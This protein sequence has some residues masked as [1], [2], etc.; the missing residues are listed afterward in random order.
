MN[1]SAWQS[2]HVTN[3]LSALMMAFHSL[4]MAKK[5]HRTRVR[6]KQKKVSTRAF[7]F[8]LVA[9][10]PRRNEPLFQLGRGPHCRTGDD[11]FN[12]IALLHTATPFA[13]NNGAKRREREGIFDEFFVGV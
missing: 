10:N 7:R 4:L 13:P 5:L 2:D 8:V 12:Q 11:V 6:T 3:L 1:C 9:N